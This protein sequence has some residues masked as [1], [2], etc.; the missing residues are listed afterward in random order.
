LR[1]RLI[2]DKGVGPRATLRYRVF[3]YEE[4]AIFAR[5][6]YRLS[7]GF[8]GAIESEYQSKDR[9]T[10]S[11]T[12]SYAA[13]DKVVFDETT[14]HRYRLQG[15][16]DHMSL[17]EKT[18]THLSYDKLSDLKMISD[19]PSSDFE[20]DT[21]RRTILS[22]KHHEETFY[23]AL[24]VTPRLNP[25]D[26]INQK[27][28][29]L[30]GSIK[31]FTLGT[32]G[33]LSENRFSL[34]YLN[35]V[36]ASD[37]THTYPTLRETHAARVSM[38]NL[39]YRPFH[40]APLHITPSLGLISFLYSNNEQG[41]GVYQTTA[42]YGG[43]LSIP[44]IKRYDRRYHHIEPYMTYEGVSV[45]TT[46][47]S[48]HYIFMIED[49]LYQLNRL[50]LGCKNRWLFATKTLDADIFA[51]HFFF[52]STL[53]GIAPKAYLSMRMQAASYLL[54]EF[55]CWNFQESVLD[56][57]NLLGEFTYNEHLAFI[58]EYRHR[59]RF[60]FRKAN[61]DSFFV[62]MAR[63]IEEL[64][65]SPLSDKRNTFLA[66]ISANLSPKW[67]CSFGS[68]YGWGRNSEP[69]YA[70][71]KIDT[72]T[73]LSSRWELKFSYTHTTNDDRFAMQMQ[74]HK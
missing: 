23:G 19:F 8:G 42:T 14:Y 41:H 38:H 66:K 52:S 69:S 24:L 54:E 7:M 26:S 30:Q 40:I 51:H 70:S 1:Y 15:I 73:L 49:G 60:D 74:L 27:L 62:D 50:T 45:P 39:L 71:F 47:L 4:L 25:F 20:I 56:T 28:P 6:D 58:L 53:T 46:S 72:T 11:T 34:G 36:Y 3:T 44:L 13:R 67:T 21:E 35:Y 43:T 10:S 33:I 55:L 22:I 64:V 65:D 17:D 57:I 9:R 48:H 12:R 61:H 32:S 2:W 29:L 18:K 63:S 68:H 37:L 59:S 31:P 5:L 16:F